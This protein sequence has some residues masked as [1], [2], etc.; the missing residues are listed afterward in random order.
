M[1]S[2]CWRA[3]PTKRACPTACPPWPAARPRKSAPHLDGKAGSR[4]TRPAIPSIRADMLKRAR[5]AGFPALVL[6]VD[7]PVASRRERQTRSGLTHPPRLTPRLLAQVARCPAW[8]LGTARLGMPRMRL[9]DGY[10]GQLTGLQLHRTCG[11]PAAH[12]ARLG[13]SQGAARWLGRAADR[14][15]R[16]GC[17]AM[18]RALEAAGVDAIWVSNHAGRQF[19][20]A[21]RHLDAARD[22]GG[23]QTAADLRQRR[24]RAG[25]TS[26]APSRLGPIS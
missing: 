7:V 1:P 10:A 12:L 11:L 18:C 6:T 19:D 2:G 5:D 15:G 4:C 25:S 8:A 14:Q 23:D 26:C 9:I 13:L 17:R 24:S 22:P 21:P 20:G 3:T 16:A